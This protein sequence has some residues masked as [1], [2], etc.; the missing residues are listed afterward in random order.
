[1]PQPD[2]AAADLIAA[3]RELRERLL[4]DP[5]R[6]TYH[7]VAPEGHCMPFDPNGAL[8]WRGKYHLGF[9]FQNERGHCWGH[10]SSRDLVHWRLHP[11]SLVPNPGDPD[12]GIFSGNAFVSKEG[13]AVLLYHGVGAGNCIALSAEDDLDHWRK[14]PTNP[15][16]A[17]PKEGDP[18][19]GKYSSWDP[20]GWLEGDTYYA[21]F[22]GNPA[23]LFRSKDLVK[24]EFLHRFPETNMPD[25]EPD[26]DISCPDFFSLGDKHMLLCISHKRGCRYYLGRFGNE[27]FHPEMHAR[28][29]WPGG[30]C[31]APESL[32][33]DRGRRIMW[34][35]ALDG[36]PGDNASIPEWS[37]TMTLPRVLS[38]GDD[39]TLRIEPVEEL[40]ALRMN[41]RRITRRVVPAEAE[42]IV[43][44]VRGD[45]LELRLTF[46]PTDAAEFGLKVRCSPD[47]VEQTAISYD[48][49]R[50]CLRVDVSRSTLNESIIYRTFNMPHGVDNPL[51]TV[52]EA[53][54]A[55]APGEPLELRV[56]LD[57]SILEVF[58]N[59]RQCV[60]QRIYPTRPDSLGVSLFARGGSATVPTL[61]AWDLAPSNPW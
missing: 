59:G 4:A 21:I 2:A 8:Y 25:V 33:D 60:T 12:T 37:G 3:A 1:M 56:F 23:T 41:H 49:E 13:E 48:A 14:L 5:H 34:A 10:A 29:N 46:A 53:P 24:W 35:W 58:A 6:P 22:G 11:P 28:M 7:F 54:F 17:I 15:I 40:A 50:Q 32:L 52:Q 55:L 38:L 36:T 39:G 27:Q 43:P 51:V 42:A 30:T 45:C 47:G 20:H 19:F 18:D 31:F 61:D 44:E 26:E 57:R 9:I 16:V